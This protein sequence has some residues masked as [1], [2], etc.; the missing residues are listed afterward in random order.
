[1]LGDGPILCSY[2]GSKAVR[3]SYASSML[4]ENSWSALHVVRGHYALVGAGGGVVVVVV[5]GKL[6]CQES[7]LRASKEVGSLDPIE[8]ADLGL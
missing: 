5:S 7:E 3:T 2:N 8:R 6:G 4:G 1:M